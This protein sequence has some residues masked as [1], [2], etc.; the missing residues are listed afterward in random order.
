LAHSGTLLLDEISE[1]GPRLQAELLRVLEQQDFERVG[2]SESVNVDVRIV[3]TSNRDL[4]AEIEAGEFRADLYYRIRGVHL[5]ISPLRERPED[6]PAL[7][8]H[9]VNIYAAE[10]RRRIL[11]LDDAMLTLFA[12]YG[13]PGNVRQLR[14]V[15]DSAVVLAE[16]NEV[17][18]ADLALRDTGDMELDTLEIAY[19]EQKLITEALQRTNNNVPDAA[20]LLG[21]G[22]A[23]LYRKIEQYHIER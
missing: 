18:P 15:L 21:I 2:G 4:S 7:V 6:I 14:N 10:S 23:T 13:W 17:R 8:W 16:E 3:C 5:T 20:K 12:R 9:F 1:T 11:H 22:R 19:W